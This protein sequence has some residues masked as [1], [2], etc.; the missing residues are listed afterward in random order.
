VLTVRAVAL[1]LMVEG[2][3][4]TARFATTARLLNVPVEHGGAP[5]RSLTEGVGPVLSRRE[6]SRIQVVERLSVR[7]YGSDRGC[8]RRSLVLARLLRPRHATVR[9]GVRRDP[10][11]TIRVHAW[12]E[13]DGIALDPQLGYEP[14]ARFPEG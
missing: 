10:D 12:T 1:H 4:R 8:L 11:G 7:L 13:L 9:L 14:L 2:S 6:I 5:F 3:L